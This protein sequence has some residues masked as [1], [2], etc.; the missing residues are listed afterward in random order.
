C[1][2]RAGASAL[3]TSAEDPVSDAPTPKNC[4]AGWSSTVT[5]AAAPWGAG[6][7]GPLS[8]SRRC[9][10]RV[11]SHNRVICPTPRVTPWVAGSEPG[12]DAVQPADTARHIDT[13]SAD[14][15]TRAVASAWALPRSHVGRPDRPSTTNPSYLLLKE[16]IDFL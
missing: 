15:T 16:T 4:W 12:L 3:S 13:T 7:T 8:A 11:V 10:L 5:S 6:G 1:S 2:R 14:A 9:P